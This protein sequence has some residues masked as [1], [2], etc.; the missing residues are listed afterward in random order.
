MTLHAAPLRLVDAAPLERLARTLEA[1]LV[2]ASTPLTRADLA[3][4]AN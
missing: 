2:I 1:L 4:A 3:A